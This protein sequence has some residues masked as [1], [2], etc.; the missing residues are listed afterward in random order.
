VDQQT[1]ILKRLFT[2][3]L[4]VHDFMLD[5]NK[6]P[7]EYNITIN[8]P[9]Y[10]NPTFESKLQALVPAFVSGA[11]S[12]KQFVGEL[13]GEALSEEERED[14]IAKLEQY[15]GAAEQLDTMFNDYM[16]E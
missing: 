12:A 1:Q 4:K 10:A 9:E 3:V 16:M 15:K 8:Y 6:V 2:L 13:W 14:E 5:E 11:M 7:G